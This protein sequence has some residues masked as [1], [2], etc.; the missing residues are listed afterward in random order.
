MNIS[1]AIS[2]KK[3]TDFE[4]QKALC[5]YRDTHNK[6]A[7]LRGDGKPLCAIT[8]GIIF[9]IF[10][11]FDDRRKID[12]ETIQAMISLADST[13]IFAAGHEEFTNQIGDVQF[14]K[15]GGITHVRNAV[16]GTHRGKTAFI[17][18]ASNGQQ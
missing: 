5:E 14:N 3:F 9:P 7:V 17:S 16:D 4:V 1:P 15:N 12:L 10:P 2:T 11:Q 18:A 8:N 13:N 6:M